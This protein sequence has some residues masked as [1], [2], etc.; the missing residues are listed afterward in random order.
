MGKSSALCVRRERNKEDS[1]ETKE[2][3]KKK[4]NIFCLPCLKIQSLLP[5][6]RAFFSLRAV[7]KETNKREKGLCYEQTKLRD[8]GSSCLLHEADLPE[9][10]YLGTVAFL[11]PSQYHCLPQPVCFLAR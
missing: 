7:L 1:A 3:W 5:E 4:Q 9:K 8:I 10:R 11:S 6:I 2:S